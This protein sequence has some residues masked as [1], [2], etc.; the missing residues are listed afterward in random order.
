MDQPYR[1]LCPTDFSKTS[2]EALRYACRLARKLDAQIELLHVHHAPLQEATVG[3]PREVSD[4]DQS[5][6]QQLEAELGKARSDLGPLCEG[7]QISTRLEVGTPYVVIC[8]RASSEGADLVVMATLGRTGLAHLLLGSVTER[9]LR[10]CEV[11]VLTVRVQ[12]D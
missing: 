8:N 3:A 9:V 11:P 12:A 6:R 10:I 7:L 1:I 5:L 4:L 2:L